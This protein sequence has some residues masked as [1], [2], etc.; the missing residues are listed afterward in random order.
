MNDIKVSF[1]KCSYTSKPDNHEIGRISKRIASSIEFINADN[2]KSFA[3]HVGEEGCTFSPATFSNNTRS[4]DTFQQMQFMV[5]DFDKGISF[6]AVKNRSERYDLNILFAYDTLSSKDYDRFR[7]VFLNNTPIKD[8]R[9][10]KAMLQALN[11]IFPEADKSCAKDISKMYFGGKGLLHYDSSIPVIDIESLFRNMTI[12]LKDKYGDTNYKRKIAEFSKESGIALN[13]NQLL[14]IIVTENIAEQVGENQI[15]KISPN[16]Y[17]SIEGNGEN[18]LNYIIN[19]SSDFT[20]DLCENRK[21]NIHR[22]FRSSILNDIYSSCKLYHEF[23]SG[24]RRLHHHELFGL[25]TNLIQ[26]ESGAAKFKKTI[27]SNMYFEDRTERYKYWN[28]SLKYIRSYNPYSCNGFC[29]YRDECT[30]GKNILSTA[31]PKYHEIE[32]LNSSAENYVSIKEVETDFSEKL[33]YAMN[34]DKNM[35]YIIKAQTALGKTQTYLELTKDTPQRVLIAVPTLK[36]KSE[37]YERASAMGINIVESPSIRDYYNDLPDDVCEKIDFLYKS[38]K[39]V[40]S[41]L[42][43][44]ASKKDDPGTV[45]TVKQFLKELDK[46]LKFNGHGITTHKRLLHMDVS[47]YDVVII[48][49]DIIYSTIIPN[50]TDIDI[51]T[52]KKL[53][54]KIA[55]GSAISEKINKVLKRYKTREYFALDEV[56]YDN[57]DDDDKPIGVDLSSFCSATRFCFRKSSDSD[58]TIKSDYLS[59]QNPVG[60]KKGTKY[61]MVSATVDKKICEYYLGEDNMEFYECKKAKYIGTLDQY[62]NNSMSRHYLSKHPESIDEIKKSFTFNHIICFMKYH[63]DDL[64]FGNTAGR[65]DL[66]GKNIGVIGTPHQPEWI[67]KLFA[68]TIGLDFDLNATVKNCT[69]VDH[70]GYRFRF[71]TYDDK[72]LRAVQFYMIESE[73]EQAI[74]RA[75]LLRENCTVSLFS[76]FPL[77]QA[78]LKEF[79]CG[80][81]DK[82]HKTND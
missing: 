70:N 52:L 54:K 24:S 15:N 2:I 14:D 56:K 7:V 60:F 20:S 12:Y 50:R 37:I 80:T 55:P 8:K 46:F 19:F 57:A 18:L 51:R 35:W 1:D 38:G 17:I 22:Q 74:G 41:Y 77:S 29:P 53:R 73:L 75:R 33:T 79:D 48:D 13:K 4:A 62:F 82:N 34:S 3:H 71:T 31:K 5:L 67:Y 72:V 39:S 10:A 25:A 30:H 16:C 49:E 44:I 26:I 36:L 65:D 47:K 61:I 11:T 21:S 68:Y 66:K 45:A 6:D 27:K 63:L 64:H 9:V 40:I 28:D 81:D 42:N 58:N 78:N 76:N 43:K 59:F 69:V 32:K 23:V